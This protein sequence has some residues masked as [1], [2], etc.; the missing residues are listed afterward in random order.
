MQRATTNHD[1][2][3]TLASLAPTYPDYAALKEAL[4]TTPKAQTKLRDAI[5][6]NMDRWR[7][8]PRDLG[9]VYLITNVPEFQLRLA[10][11]GRNIRTYRT[12][13]GKPGAPPPAIGRKGRSG[14]VQPDM[15]RAAIHRRGR[16]LGATIARP[17]ARR[18]QGDADGGWQPA[19]RAAAGQ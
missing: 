10:V 18:V 11:N 8:L 16:R 14:G 9:P 12:I 5:R 13:V 2:P 17:S 1:V 3:G 7:W 6:I 4:A 19:S 15:D